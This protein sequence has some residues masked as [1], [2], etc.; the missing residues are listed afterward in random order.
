M[1]NFV[2][3]IGLIGIAILCLALLLYAYTHYAK[4]KTRYD[5]HLL[6]NEQALAAAIT[7]IEEDIQ[8]FTRESSDIQQEQDELSTFVESLESKPLFAEVASMKEAGY[9]TC[10]DT[11]LVYEGR[12]Y[13]PL[14]LLEKMSRFIV[15]DDG[16]RVGT[17]EL[18]IAVR[19]L[20]VDI[21]SLSL[22][23][24]VNED[25]I[26]IDDMYFVSDAYLQGHRLY[27]HFDKGLRVT[28][29]E[30]TLNTSIIESVELYMTKRLQEIE[31]AKN[32]ECPH[33]LISNLQGFKV[34]GDDP[35]APRHI[36]LESSHII[37]HL[38]VDEWTSL[39]IYLKEGESL[40][41]THQLIKSG[42]YS[43]YDST[44]GLLLDSDNASIY[45]YVQIFEY[46]S[47]EYFTP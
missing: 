47:K 33:E 1:S 22:K 27:L 11:G 3:R 28:T 35:L 39:E 10:F 24:V 9:Y 29:K 2:K 38:I 16:R 20:K 42:P 4:E 12:N 41:R 13:Y 26:I 7:R 45:P 5:E 14:S 34:K 37:I 6:T 18:S 8:H 46:L 43:W 44:S 15:Y 19:E 30:D 17:R 40:S 31:L 21:T 36:L 23:F 25:M 32:K